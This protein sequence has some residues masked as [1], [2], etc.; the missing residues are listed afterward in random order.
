M[1]IPWNSLALYNI[2]SVSKNQVDP[3]PTSRNI[4]LSVMFTLKRDSSQVIVLNYAHL[5]LSFF[6]HQTIKINKEFAHDFLPQHPRLQQSPGSQSVRYDFLVRHIS[7]RRC[8]AQCGTHT[9][10]L[11]WAFQSVLVASDTCLS[12]ERC[13]AEGIRREKEKVVTM[14]LQMVL[15]GSMH[16]RDTHPW[17]MEMMRQN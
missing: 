13:S 8:K 5:L 12:W 11:C 7:T 9:N 4:L 6:L 17:A 10:G 16:F 2:Y 3:L 1:L 14:R 15:Q